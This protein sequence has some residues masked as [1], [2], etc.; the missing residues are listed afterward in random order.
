MKPSVYSQIFLHII[1]AVKFRE[2]L[3]KK[4]FK[5]DLMKY[6]SKTITA[7][8]HKAIIVNGYLDHVHLLVGFNTKETVSDFVRD[9]KRSSSIFINQNKFVKGNFQWQNGYGVFSYSKSQIKNVYNY[10]LRQEEHHGVK[11]FRE[12]YLAFLN[13][14]EIEYDKRFLPK[15][16]D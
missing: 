9:I 14:F 6:I 16:F 11:T 5:D 2:R 4:G 3:I 7:K 1:F 8:G 13:K 10:I 12:E 15:F